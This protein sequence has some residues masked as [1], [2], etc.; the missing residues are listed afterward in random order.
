MS[1]SHCMCVH[2]CVCPLTLPGIYTICWIVLSVICSWH[3]VALLSVPA[4]YATRCFL[5]PN[6]ILHQGNPTADKL[7]RRISSQQ[8][9]AQ[10]LKVVYQSKKPD[11]LAS[12]PFF[13]FS[14]TWNLFFP[15]LPQNLDPEILNTLETIYFLYI[16][17]HRSASTWW[18]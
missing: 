7:I 17:I 3:S 13:C 2:V 1:I 18:I 8:S 9:W 11:F 6:A 10:K 14:P 5:P 4:A 12:V 15:S 16:S